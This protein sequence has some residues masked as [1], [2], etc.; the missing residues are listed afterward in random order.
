M[1]MNRF[2]NMFGGGFVA[3]GEAFKINSKEREEEE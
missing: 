1:S 2:K 3:Q